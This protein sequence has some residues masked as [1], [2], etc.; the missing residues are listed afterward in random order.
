MKLRVIAK[1]AEGKDAS[2][3]LKEGKIYLHGSEFEIPEDRGKELLRR[4]E[5][6]YPVVELVRDK[7]QKENNTEISE[8]KEE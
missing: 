4:K 6:N 1:T 8:S 5:G 2:L 3:T 7:K